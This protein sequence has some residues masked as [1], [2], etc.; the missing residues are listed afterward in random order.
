MYAAQQLFFVLGSTN[1]RRELEIFMSSQALWIKAIN[2]FDPKPI[3]FAVPSTFGLIP[4]T[5]LPSSRG[6]D[7]RP[8]VIISE[9]SDGQNVETMQFGVTAGLARGYNVVLFEGPGQMSLLF[10]RR[11]PFT[12]DWQKK[13]S[14]PC[15]SGRRQR[16]M[17]ARSA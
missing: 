12:A 17:S 8:T 6:N 7:R 10:Q 2:H 13:S 1:G 4:G 5:F 9:G 15:W 11:I 16:A 14:A 3:R